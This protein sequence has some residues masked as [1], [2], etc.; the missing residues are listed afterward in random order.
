M[1]WV[2][3]MGL[4]FGLGE[5]NDFAAVVRSEP[6]ETRSPTFERNREDQPRTK[7]QEAECRQNLH[8]SGQHKHSNGLLGSFMLLYVCTR[9]RST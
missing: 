1:L 4:G 3:H 9:S 5:A 8:N 6:L 2:F 7:R